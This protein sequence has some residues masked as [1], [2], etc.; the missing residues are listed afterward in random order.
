MSPGQD[1]SE[2]RI[3][4]IQRGPM[5]IAGWLGQREKQ[6]LGAQDLSH[7]FGTLVTLS[8]IRFSTFRV[9]RLGRDR[10]DNLFRI[11]NEPT[12]FLEVRVASLK[13]PWV[14]HKNRFQD[15]TTTVQDEDNVG[16]KAEGWSPLAASFSS[17]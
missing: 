12:L 10:E 17:W 6:L 14:F 4:A 9:P 2:V 16:L 15:P 8:Y 3:T 7:P 1:W 5:E 13:F 11:P